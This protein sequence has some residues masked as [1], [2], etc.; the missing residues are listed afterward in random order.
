MEGVVAE[1]GREGGSEGRGGV[2]GRREGGR[3][4][5]EESQGVSKYWGMGNWGGRRR[6]VMECSGLER[7]AN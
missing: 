2:D 3:K 5:R 6:G 4:T 7:Q 1:R